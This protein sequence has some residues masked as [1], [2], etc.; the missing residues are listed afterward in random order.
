MILQQRKLAHGVLVEFMIVSQ[1]S[2]K[3]SALEAS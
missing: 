3:I 1:A 2:T